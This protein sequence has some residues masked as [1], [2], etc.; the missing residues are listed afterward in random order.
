LLN[1]DLTVICPKVGLPRKMKSGH[2]SAA[3]PFSR[4]KSA[5]NNDVC[6]DA[7]RTMENLTRPLTGNQYTI[8]HGDY[9]ATIC[10]QGAILRLLKWKGHD[11]IAGFDAD[12]PCP[13]SNGNLLIPYPNRIQDGTYTFEGRTYT[14]PIDEHD[15]HN[16]IHGMGYRSF[17]ELVAL[18]EDAVELR[19]RNP[20][21]L[22]GYPFH[23][24]A[25]ALYRVTDQGLSL[26]ISATNN[27]P[28]A[29]PW[30]F[31]MHPWISNG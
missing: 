23:V 10:E 19:W 20:A 6:L 26:T 17:W 22:K 31:G 4:M 27:G 15:R 3:R 24:E 14:L 28:S 21:T 2:F 30:A 5:D 8:V 9:R 11:L 16:A 18:R 25:T 29:A 1:G 12:Q 13:C 7:R